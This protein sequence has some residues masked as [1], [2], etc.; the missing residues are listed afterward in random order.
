MA[1]TS[2]YGIRSVDLAVRDLDATKAFYEAQWGLKEVGRENGSIYMRATGK[3]H[4][5]LVIHQ[6]PKAKLMSLN[7]GAKSRADVD[8]LHAQAKAL[9]A[10]ILETPHELAK[11]AGG[12]YG[13]ALQSPEGQRVTISAGVAEN[14]DHEQDISKPERMSHVVLNAAKYDEQKAFY[15]DVLGFRL[16]DTTDFMDF[17]RCCEDHHSVAVAR[18]DGASMNHMAYELPNMEGLMRGAGRMKQSGF[19]IGWGIGRHGP[20]DNV[21]SYF[22]EP[23]GFVT[24]YTTGMEQV[25]NDTYEWHGPDYWATAFQRPCRWG[26]AMD[27]APGFRNAMKGKVVEERNERCEDVIAKGLAQGLKGAAE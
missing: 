8:A 9:A 25:A 22:I 15:R 11:I 23:N 12:G 5:V 18:A 1:Q 2:A 3:D 6:A 26:L 7:L 10:T 14:A 21:F 4:H 16:S 17:L 24:E 27:M 19:D 20:G 13:F